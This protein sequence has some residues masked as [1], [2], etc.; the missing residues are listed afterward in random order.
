MEYSGIR[1]E[2]I[3]PTFRV[4]GRHKASFS[5][6]VSPGISEEDLIQ[7][8]FAFKEARGRGDLVKMV[9]LSSIKVFSFFEIYVF[10]DGKWASREKLKKFIEGHLHQSGKEEEFLREYAT[11]IQGHYLYSFRL[12]EEEGTIG[13]N[14]GLDTVKNYRRLF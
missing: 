1:N 4:I 7:L 2:T 6:L 9:P 12:K 3:L 13:Y 11:H 10:T 8:V 14:D 5:I